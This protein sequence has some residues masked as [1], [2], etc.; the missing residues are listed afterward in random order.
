MTLYYTNN[1]L[2]SFRGNEYSQ[3]HLQWRVN[4]H[5]QEMEVNEYWNF[6][7]DQM[8]TDLTFVIDKVLEVT[9]S[10]TLA[11]VGYSQ[12]E[13]PLFAFDFIKPNCFS[14]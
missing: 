13:M 6:S 3:E 2:S 1:L 11:F 4:E 9:N 10:S 14:I 12:G 5:T 7:F 8:A